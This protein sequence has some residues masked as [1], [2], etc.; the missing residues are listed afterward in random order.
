L[1]NRHIN[2][3]QRR[4]LINVNTDFYTFKRYCKHAPGFVGHSYQIV[5][6]RILPN[7]YR[8]LIPNDKTAEAESLTNIIPRVCLYGLSFSQTDL[9]IYFSPHH[10]ENHCS[11]YSAAG[12]E[13]FTYVKT[14]LRQNPVTLQRHR[15]WIYRC[16]CR[17]E[18]LDQGWANFISEGP[19]FG[20]QTFCRVGKDQRNI[21]LSIF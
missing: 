20:L 8:G 6:P 5:S 4:N 7:E 9:S 17:R 21:L 3:A 16:S 18:S 11:F 19:N 15:Q 1:H 12:A 14:I 10:E 2:F 13:F